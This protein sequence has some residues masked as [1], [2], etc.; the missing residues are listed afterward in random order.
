MPY[1]GM[2]DRL[3]V[4]KALTNAATLLFI[5]YIIA[6]P[7]YIYFEKL[8]WFDAIYFTTITITTVG[9]GD[10]TPQTT[11]GKVFTM[12]LILAGMSI[13]FY[14][15]SHLGQF[16]EAEIDPH[17]RKRIRLLRSITGL[18]GSSKSEME[19]LKEKMQERDD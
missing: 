3:T 7:F 1:K 4:R 10:I 15:I 5:L 16:R 14:H 6:V 11:A 17:V 19:K 2:E 12:L 18:S 13:L 8:G 9:Y